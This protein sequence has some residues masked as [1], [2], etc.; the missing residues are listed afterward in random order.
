M[1]PNQVHMELHIHASL[2]HASL[3]GAQYRIYL[4]FLHLLTTP[5]PPKEQKVLKMFSLLI[6]SV[7]RKSITFVGRSTSFTICPSVK[8]SFEDKDE[9]EK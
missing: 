9:H 6:L 7:F 5:P 3:C 4:D 8:G 1:V 2:M